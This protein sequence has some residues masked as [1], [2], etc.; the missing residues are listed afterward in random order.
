MVY[1]GINI[2]WLSLSNVKSDVFITVKSANI[3]KSG[4]RN[5]TRFIERNVFKESF[6]IAAPTFYNQLPAATR[7]ITNIRSFKI[8]CHKH[9]FQGFIDD[10]LNF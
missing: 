4:W 7:S 10:N 6:P 9:Y 2:G 1:L 3:G 5:L 8:A